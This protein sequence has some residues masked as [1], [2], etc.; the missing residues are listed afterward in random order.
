MDYISEAERLKL[1]YKGFSDAGNKEQL[2]AT[3]S[4]IAADADNPESDADVRE[5]CTF[6]I[7]YMFPLY[8]KLAY[9]SNNRFIHEDLPYYEP[10]PQRIW[11]AK[12][13]YTALQALD[14]YAVRELIRTIGCSSATLTQLQ[15]AFDAQDETLFTH[16]IDTSDCDLSLTSCICEDIW[17][18]VTFYNDPSDEDLIVGMDAVASIL[19]DTDYPVSRSS[20]ELSEMTEPFLN[21]GDKE[22]YRQK[23][24]Q[25]NHDLFDYMCEYYRDNYNRFKLKERKQIEPLILGGGGSIGTGFHLPDDYFAF[26]HESSKHAEFFDLRPDVIEAGAKHFEEFVNSLSQLGY[27][28]SS[29]VVKQLFAYRFSGRMRP[30]KVEP[31]EWHGHNGKSYELVYLVRNMTEQKSGKY[32]KMKQFFTGPEWFKSGDSSNANGADYQLKTLLHKHYPTL[33]DQL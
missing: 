22:E 14:T 1:Y 30:K 19:S 27:I 26:R 6:L 5:V 9:V 3:Y 12:E 24:T 25:Y 33:P 4:D 11:T 16:I 28:D 21:D 29:P 17:P 20:K 32:N 2:A 23:A 13:I 15:Q 31:I 18:R 7:G 8:H 10:T